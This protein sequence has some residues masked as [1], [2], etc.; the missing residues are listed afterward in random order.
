MELMPFSISKIDQDPEPAVRICWVFPCF[1]ILGIMPCTVAVSQVQAPVLIWEHVTILSTIAGASVIFPARL[2]KCCSSSV[3]LELLTCILQFSLALERGW[4]Q[5]F[6]GFVSCCWRSEEY[7]CCLLWLTPNNRLWMLQLGNTW[8][9][10]L[11]SSS[12]S[13]V[14]GNSLSRAP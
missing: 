3:N 5:H 9:H 1:Q 14:T 6:C 11:D 8:W 4:E 13:F 7:L 2:V 12:S 10:C